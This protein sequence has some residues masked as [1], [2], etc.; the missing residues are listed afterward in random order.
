MELETQV[1]IAARLHYL[2]SD[3]AKGVLHE[4]GDAY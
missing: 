3:L 4:S 1:L 2:E